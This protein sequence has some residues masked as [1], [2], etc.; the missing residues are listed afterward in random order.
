MLAYFCNQYLICIIMIKGYTYN[1]S[2][3]PP[4]N[5]N[6]W[7]KSGNIGAQHILIPT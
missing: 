3:Y 5:S 7:W 4:K 2:S 6:V 1:T